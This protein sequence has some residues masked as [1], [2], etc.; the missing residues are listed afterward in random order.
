MPAVERSQ[1]CD[2]Q[3]I[4]S[5]YLKRGYAMV[6]YSSFWSSTTQTEEAAI[7]QG[8]EVGADLVLILNP[9]YAG[10]STSHIPITTPNVARSY[11]TGSATAYGSSG[12]SV[13]AYGS[14]TTT[15][16][17]T[18]TNYIPV[19]IDRFDYG[20]VF[21]VKPRFILGV[22]P[23]DL[24]DSER[25]RLQSNK[26]VAVNIVVDDTPA[27]HSDILVGDIITGIDG[28]EVS[29]SKYLESL[30]EERSKNT[31]SLSIIRDG[32]QIKKS[33]QLD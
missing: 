5:A 25:Q 33:I 8:K 14:G 23:R 32:K 15:T 27:F 6:G 30:L 28:I 16:Y 4:L 9:K 18:T 20:A 2:S 11:S 31:V 1:P 22:A 19:T 29:N 10:S 21:F 12:G 13:S 26:G 3:T 17:S 7:Q 24:N